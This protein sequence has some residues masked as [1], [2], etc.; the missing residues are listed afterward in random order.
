MDQRIWPEVPISDGFF[1]SLQ[2]DLL[3]IPIQ[4]FTVCAM[5]TVYNPHDLQ[6]RHYP[7]FW[8]AKNVA[9]REVVSRTGCDLAHTIVVG[10]QWVKD[11]VVRQYGVAPDKVQVIPEA[12]ATQSHPEPTDGYLD[13]VRSKYG[14]EQPFMLYPGVAWPH[15]NHLRLFEALACLRDERGLTLR[16][17]CPGARYERF[18]S[19]IENRVAELRLE[20]QVKFLGYVP[21]DDLRALYR[22]AA[23]L[24]MPSLFEAVSL[25]IFEAWS[26][27]LPVACS[28]VTA[29]P[30][31]VRDAACLFDPV[32]VGSIATVL[33]AV[34]TNGALQQE[35]RARG[36]HRITDF[37]W[38]RT[39]KAYRAVYRRAASRAL[40][41]EDRW[42]LQWNWM[43]EPQRQGELALR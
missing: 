36:H 8:D 14:L 27:G 32:D 12:A 23:C 39:A 21:D 31:Q 17:V 5:P 4:P 24:V 28:N 25:P 3:H 1:E 7:Q 13:T 43:Q 6:H 40:T 9:W 41:D 11:D 19:R 26:E 30:E 35:L 10:S 15:K 2:C 33:A 42:L 38:L 29:L 18:W 34:M 22:L 37:D 16:L 20:R